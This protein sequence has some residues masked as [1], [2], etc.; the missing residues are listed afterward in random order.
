MWRLLQWQCSFSILN[1]FRKYFFNICV[2]LCNVFH[3]YWWNKS[4]TDCPH[5]SKHRERVM[6]KR[7]LGFYMRWW[8][9]SLVYLF[10]A[11]LSNQLKN[12]ND[13]NWK[14][15]SKKTNQTNKITA[16]QRPVSVYIFYF[17][18]RMVY[19]W[20]KASTHAHTQL[21]EMSISRQIEIFYELKQKCFIQ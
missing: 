15:G 16:F 19:I 7:K 17:A 2:W 1:K 9:Y 13:D 8:M 18:L 6:V 4:K 12:N 20:H 14:K 11:I 10:V 5:L 3:L 21:N